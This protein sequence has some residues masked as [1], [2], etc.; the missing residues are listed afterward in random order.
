[1][2]AAQERLD[3]RSGCHAAKILPVGDR[4]TCNVWCL[5]SLLSNSTNLDPRAFPS[6]FRGKIPGDEFEFPRVENA[7]EWVK[8]ENNG[9]EY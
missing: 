2:T 9:S 4:G 1:M 6:I 3:M 8:H 7:T 5:S